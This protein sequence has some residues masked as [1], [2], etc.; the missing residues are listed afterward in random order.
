[1]SDVFY[2][3]RALAETLLDHRCGWVLAA[4]YALQVA[5]CAVANAITSAIPKMFSVT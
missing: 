1:V 3:S 2:L 5:F 4:T